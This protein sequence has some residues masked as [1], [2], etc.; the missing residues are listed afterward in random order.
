MKRASQTLKLLPLLVL[1]T[2]LAGCDAAGMPNTD[3]EAIVLGI[4]FIVAIAAVAAIFI[5][6]IRSGRE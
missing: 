4:V 5:T 6:L 2:L 3:T 1:V